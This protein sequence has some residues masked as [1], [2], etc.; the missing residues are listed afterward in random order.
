MSDSRSQKIGR[1][2]ATPLRADGKLIDEWT[3][4]A[5][6]PVD[7]KEQQIS[8]SVRVSIVSIPGKLTFRA[9]IPD[10]DTIENSDIQALREQVEETLLLH[11]AVR[12]GNLWEDWLRFTVSNKDGG[13]VDTNLSSALSIVV[14]P[15]KRGVDPSTREAYILDS[16]GY[17]RL[18]KAKPFRG[19]LADIL[20][21]SN[22]AG[23]D[24]FILEEKKEASYV[25]A[26]SDN[27]AALEDISNRMRQLRQRLL[28]GFTQSKTEQ[29][30]GCVNTLLAVPP[31]DEV[32]PASRG[33]R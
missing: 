24:G 14:E 15:I 3:L 6:K 11:S 1:L 22:S 29:T 13:K 21:I 19:R 12:L 32:K 20:G 27:I 2:N 30:L 23:S 9:R 25:P 33:P 31:K 18:I 28:E 26:T 4:Y 5:S 10:L 17:A 16:S 7:Q 8:I